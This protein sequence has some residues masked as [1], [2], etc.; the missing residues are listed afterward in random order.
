MK[1]TLYPEDLNEAGQTKHISSIT[2]DDF[3]LEVQIAI[4]TILLYGGDV[5]YRNYCN[6]HHI[7]N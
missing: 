2:K 1:L 7:I 3:L 5:T 4:A 6:G